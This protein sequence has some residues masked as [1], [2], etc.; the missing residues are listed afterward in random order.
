MSRSAP[1]FDRRYSMAN[2]NPWKMTR[3]RQPTDGPRYTH[4]KLFMMSRRRRNPTS[5]FQLGRYSQ[6]RGLSPCEN[7]QYVNFLWEKATCQKQS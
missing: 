3:I 5:W 6:P 1:C 4:R 7:R 2:G